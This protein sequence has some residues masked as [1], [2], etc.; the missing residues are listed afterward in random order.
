[1]SRSGYFK[2]SIIFTTAHSGAILCVWRKREREKERKRERKREMK[3]SFL[4]L[5]LPK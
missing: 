4:L 1:M 3:E 2:Q 5:L